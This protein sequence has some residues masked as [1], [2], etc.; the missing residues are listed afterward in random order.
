MRVPKDENARGLEDEAFLQQEIP[1]TILPP[2]VARIDVVS[3]PRRFY[4]GTRVQLDAR[5]Y[6][7]DGRRRSDAELVYASDAPEVAVVGK[8]G[9]LRLVSPGRARLS[10]SAD[11]ASARLEVEVVDNPVESLKLQASATRARTGEVVHL[12]AR[13]LDAAGKSLADVPVSFTF[14]AETDPLAS[15]GPSSGWIRQDGRFVADL[16]GE[17]TVVATAGAHSDSIVVSVDPRDVQRE[18]ELVGH[19][20]VSDRATSDL[21]VW[22][23]VDGRDYA[24]TGTH[25]ASGHAYIWDVTDPANL[26]IID[27]VR[28]DARTVNDVKISEDGHLAVV[29]REGAS[30][31]RNGIVILDVSEPQVGVRV[32]ASYDDELTGGV[33]NVYVH[34]RHVYALSAGQRYDII[35]I[36]DPTKPH[37][38]GRFAL[39]NPDRSIHDVVVKDGI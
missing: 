17:Y 39:D 11:E 34:D 19:G 29:S 20:R 37:R 6:D 5:A 35:N 16:P 4:A 9:N 22:E 14:S 32:L 2:P 27:T 30:N 3:P 7:A 24:I 18:I 1:L 31:R 38:V 13:V 36:E 26:E 21:W 10:V 23:G 28:V 33:H 15:G 25:S 8:T 12:D